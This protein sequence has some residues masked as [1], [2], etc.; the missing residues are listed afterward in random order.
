[1]TGSS[2]GLIRRQPMEKRTECPKCMHDDFEVSEVGREDGRMT[3]EVR[4]LHCGHTWWETY[5]IK[6]VDIEDV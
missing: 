2:A 6:L 5:E 3:E 4:C 1:M